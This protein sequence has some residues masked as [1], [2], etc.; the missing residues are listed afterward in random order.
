MTELSSRWNL[1]GKT[2]LITGA[3]KGIGLATAA[4]LLALGCDVI[5]VARGN[6]ELER[7]AAELQETY[8]ERKVLCLAADVSNSD[9]LAKI[10]EG[11]SSL[12]KIDVLVNNAGTNIR[13]KTIEF[14]SE[15]IKFLLDTNLLSAF[16]L[17]RRLHSK[18]K[19]SK[20]AS[21]VFVSSIAG[22]GSVLTGSVYAMTK[23]ALNQLTRSLAHEWAKDGIRVN[24]VA[25]GFIR[26][27]LT[28]A[29]M[30]RPEVNNLLDSRTFLKR[31]GEAEEVADVIA[32]LALP[33]ASYM[34]GQVLVVDGGMTS[35]TAQ[36]LLDI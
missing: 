27:P 20:A 33:A 25:P 16:E 28:G 11:I 2:A 1:T 18:M 13:K 12:E 36:G 24:A 21:L 8:S 10:E 26:T 34:T 29:L 9:G 6:A 23:A 35:L 22:I 15:D 5:M 7:R 14:T 17:S 3:S 32:F 30:A 31:V 4:S 19:A